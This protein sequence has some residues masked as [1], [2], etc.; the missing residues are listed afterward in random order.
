MEPVAVDVLDRE[1]AQ[2]PRFPLERFHDPGP[3]R[4]QLFVRRI[5]VGG[6]DPVHDRL[7]RA[8]SPAKEDRDALRDTAPIPLSG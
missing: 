5:E 2:T 7:E 6:K 1:L 3:E 4:A 8:L